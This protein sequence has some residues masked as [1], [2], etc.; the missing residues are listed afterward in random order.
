V[1]KI[2][3]RVPAQIEMG[4][5]GYNCARFR[6]TLRHRAFFATSKSRFDAFRTFSGHE[7]RSRWSIVSIYS[8]SRRLIPNVL[9]DMIGC[10]V[11]DFW[12]TMGRFGTPKTAESLS[13]TTMFGGT[14]TV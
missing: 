14:R 2:A 5:R 1:G 13:S 10:Q 11:V 9:G 3:T 4:S 12:K 7:R 8:S 6:K